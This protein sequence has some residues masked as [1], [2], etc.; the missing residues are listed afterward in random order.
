MN[1]ERTDS[2]NNSSKEPIAI[3]GMGCR[4]PG[5]ANSPEAF[6][7]L[8]AN[9]VDAITEVPADRWNVDSFY[10]PEGKPGKIST[11]WGGFVEN[12]DQFD[13]EFFGISPR[14]VWS[15]PRPS[16]QEHA[17]DA[18][19]P[20]RWTLSN[21]GSWRPPGRLWKMEGKGQK[22]WLVQIRGYLLAYTP[23]ITR[24]Y[25]VWAI[26]IRS[27]CTLIWVVLT[28]SQPTASPICLILRE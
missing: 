25:R 27:T 12:L 13:A 15:M 4:F 7:N 6:W 8:L 5:G 22:I 19:K 21:G 2:K 24:K 26:A 16:G 14:G 1:Q 18:E 28:V 10:D 3:I 9:G 11:R 20:V 17:E 23:A